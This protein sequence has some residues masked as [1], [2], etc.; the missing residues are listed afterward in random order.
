MSVLRTL[1]PR[2]ALAGAVLG[3]LVASLAWTGAPAADS[4]S[5]PRPYL[6]LG[7]GVSHVEP[8]SSNRTLAVDDAS[9]SA[10]ELF[11]G[12]E[13]TPRIAVEAYAIDLGRADIDFD[14]RP[15]G[16]VDYRVAGLDVVRR[17]PFGGT[18]DGRGW[19]G[20][21]SLGVGHLDTDGGPL[22][23]RTDH[24]TH[25]AVGA[26]LEYRLGAWAARLGVRSHDED[27]R[28]AGASLM[29]RLG[30]APT[31]A[32]SPLTRPVAPA[33]RASPPS[34]PVED[35]GVVLRFAFDSAELE[36]RA[37]T[38]LGT[39]VSELSDAG[40]TDRSREP[41][42]ALAIDGHADETG[43][44]A[45]NLGLSKRRASAVAAHLERLGIGPHRLDLRAFGESRPI[46]PNDTAEGRALNRRAEIVPRRPLVRPPG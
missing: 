15:A 3:T 7:A 22:Q 21:A 33:R 32:R 10:L 9:S 37:R 13:L 38:L 43:T 17:V 14:G 42:C 44:A 41:A 40:C 6:G 34:A 5:T 35:T 46:A 23:V 31:P 12:V 18:L 39:L 45:Y 25:L 11:A 16:A 26:G 28:S 19:N 27:A 8:A 24:H 29:R 1:G 20:Y 36:P 2:P 4:G 30:A